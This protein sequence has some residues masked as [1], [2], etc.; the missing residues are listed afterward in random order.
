MSYGRVVWYYFLNLFSLKIEFPKKWI[1]IFYYFL[2]VSEESKRPCGQETRF[3]K[4]SY[5]KMSKKTGFAIVFFIFFFVKCTTLKLLPLSDIYIYIFLISFRFYA[6]LK[7]ICNFL[8][9]TFELVCNF[10]L[11]IYRILLVQFL[12][13]KN[14]FFCEIFWSSKKII[15]KY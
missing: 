15:V 8:F 6:L 10:Q 14:V 2:N 11:T 9:E 7:Y 4:K 5:L 3:L 13:F 12:M 1:L